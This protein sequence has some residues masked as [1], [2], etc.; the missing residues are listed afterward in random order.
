MIGKIIISS[1]LWS[2]V[3][4][5]VNIFVKE[6]KTTSYIVSIIHATNC[7][8]YNLYNGIHNQDYFTEYD[9]QSQNYDL[10]VY[11]SIGYFLKDIVTVVNHFSSDKTTLIHHSLAMISGLYLINTNMNQLYS[12]ALFTELSTP[13]YNIKYLLNDRNMKHTKIY[14]T[15]DIMF[16]ISFTISRIISIPYFL[17]ISYYL[18]KSRCS[19]ND[20]ITYQ[21]DYIPIL[22]MLFFTTLNLY[23]YRILLIIVNKKLCNVK[24]DK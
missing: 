2:C 24:D 13:F 14:K 23:W 18:S 20:T 17:Y 6:P 22:N 3:N 19:L 10:I 21:I 16:F 11:H 9:V 4:S 15:N 12:L 7:I 8:S 1:L 5:I